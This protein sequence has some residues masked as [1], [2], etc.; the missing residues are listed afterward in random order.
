MNRSFRLLVR[1]FF[2]Q[3]F[4]VEASASDGGLNATALL[5]LMASPG[6]IMSV[7]LFPKY[8]SF[9]R[10]INRV[11]AFD[12]DAAAQPDKYTFIVLSMAVAGLVVM[13]R[14]ESM[15]L[16]RRDFLNLAPLPVSTTTV[17]IARS[18]ALAAFMAIFVLVTNL[19]STLFF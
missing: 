10:W 15:F 8:S 7:L 9:F 13:I 6:F 3:F 5:A 14:W 1:F 17:L 19:C 2:L 11:F 12:R 4:Q 16:D 18:L